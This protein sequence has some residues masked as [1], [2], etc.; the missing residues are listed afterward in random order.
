MSDGAL[1]AVSV[2][3][4][5]AV[6]A[7]VA[8]SAV[9]IAAIVVGYKQH[10][11]GL[12]HERR[13]TDLAHVREIFDVA[14]A[15]LHRVATA[16]DGVRLGLTQW[17][18]GFFKY[19]RGEERFRA[20]ERAGDEF[21]VLRER[22]AVRLGGDHEAVATFTA[23]NEAVLEIYRKLE[24]LKLEPDP[25]PGAA[26][27]QVREF[28]RET[29]AAITAQRKV[30]DDRRRRFMNAAHRTAGAQLPASTRD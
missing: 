1:A 4:V 2:P 8:P 30:F 22:L 28:F 5:V 9:A 7:V 15:H 21:D 19:E 27:T 11:I 10:S 17:G 18:F 23:A 25:D 26:E 14:A 24:L 20:L 12:Q 6:F 3:D 16:L 29:Q 13:L